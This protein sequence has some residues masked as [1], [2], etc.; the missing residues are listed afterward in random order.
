M[1]GFIARLKQRKL[2][3]WALAYVAFAFAL[4]QGVD[5]VAAKFGW[6][7]S[8][9]RILIIASCIGFFVTLL[10]A[11]YHGDQGR[12]RA[13]GTELLLI[14]LVLAVGGGLLWKFAGVSANRDVTETST[15]LVAQAMPRTTSAASTAGNAQAQSAAAAI[16]AKSIAVLPFENLSDNKDNVYF[17]DGLSEEILNSLARIDGLRV[18][19]RTSS[20][21]FKGK[22]VDSPTIG[23]RLGVANL[24]EGSVRR[25]GERARITAQLIRASDGTQLWSQTYDRTVTDSL[26]VQL[27]I[28][29]QVAGVLNVVLDDKQRA[30][31]RAAGVKNVDAFI[32]YQKGWKLYIDAHAKP[33][34]NLIDG[35]RQA[36]VEFDK[37]T[38][39]DP[40]FSFAYY[41]EADLYEHTLMSDGR[42]RAELLDAQRAAL[43][44]L[45]RAGATSPDPQQRDLALAERQML[46]DDWHGLAD[47]I[48]TA[49]KQPGCS[50]PNWMPVF[51]SAFGYGD[52][53]ENLGARVNVCDPLNGINYHTRVSAA[54]ATG[55]PQRALD[56]WAK[57]ETT[58]GGGP[59]PTSSQAI[60][61]TMLGRIA[62]AQATLDSMEPSGDG[63]YIAQLIVGEAAGTDPAKLNASLQKV[64]RNSSKF[65][66]WDVTDAVV[67][68][69]S[70]DRAEADRH[71]AALDARPAGGLLLAIVVT[72][73][74]CGAPFD[75]DATPRFKALLAESGLRWPP[76]ETIKYPARA[77]HHGSP[78][79]SAAAAAKA[80]VHD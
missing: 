46:S 56:I 17:S 49:L 37:A 23:R 30:R 35:L 4:L 63:Y 47:R 32:A 3:Q 54:L 27:D 45:E 61:L 62:E 50:A 78:P 31:M 34:V 70:G 8:V 67:A 22:D 20:F 13:S 80:R 65:E 58:F 48:E 43:H 52:L 51:A 69:L 29:E 77:A 2:V 33:G 24:L 75:L 38:A 21:Q 26:A 11:W 10:L 5:I 74:Q 66:S 1:T 42:S 36:N 53:I 72:E 18:I 55:H 25:E 60:A 73:C 59:T 6:P 28:A 41:A 12:Q 64:D 57:A 7:D 15:T 16:P 71:A 40:D 76:P 79:V 19:G 39:L 44:T 14:A 9:E 68:A